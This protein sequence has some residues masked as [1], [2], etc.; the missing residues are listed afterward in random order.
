M[1]LLH[2]VFE[3][4]D[5]M[6]IYSDQTW[7][8]RQ[9]SIIHDSVYN[10]EIVDQRNDRP[11]WAQVGFNDTLSLWIT[12]EILPSPVNVTGNG[13]F[14]LQDM[15]PIRA[16]P[17][18]LHFEIDRPSEIKNSYLL[19]KDIGDIQGGRLHDGGILKPIS[20]STPVL[21]IHTFDMGQNMVGWC[22][23]NF[24]G[25]RG[26]GIYIRHAEVL[27]QPVVSSG[28]AHGGIY[29]ENLRGATQ[30]D[31]YILSGDPNGETYEPR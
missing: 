25:P 23:F 11:N 24:H 6:S 22:R 5:D 8:G 15:P 7:E 13:L 9:G 14:V 2:I 1:F 26:L 4:S 20:V 21:G 31:N 19:E 17:D 16:G 10:G 3:N 27:A 12:P 18:A 30:T 28:Q 29:T